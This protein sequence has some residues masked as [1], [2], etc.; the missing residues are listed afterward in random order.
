[1]GF[2]TWALINRAHRCIIKGNPSFAWII[3]KE[4]IFY[5]FAPAPGTQWARRGGFILL[6]KEKL[7]DRLKLAP[8][9]DMWRIPYLSKLLEQ[10]GQMYYQMVDTEEV[11]DL[12]DSICLN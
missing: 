8:D 9:R 10:R 4:L 5:F 6:V 7:A 3:K 2:L 12:I 1:M 11:T